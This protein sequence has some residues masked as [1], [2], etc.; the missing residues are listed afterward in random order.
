MR[1]VSILGLSALGLGAT[2]TLSGCDRSANAPASPRTSEIVHLSEAPIDAVPW[3]PNVRPVE[4]PKPA[5]TLDETTGVQPP[6]AE[7]STTTTSGATP[8]PT[9]T[10]TPPPDP[11]RGHRGPAC[12]QLPVRG[13]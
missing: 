13:R 10:V 3:N 11:C 9:V 8:T 1:H 7:A 4:A 5:E 2:I 12:D 6:E